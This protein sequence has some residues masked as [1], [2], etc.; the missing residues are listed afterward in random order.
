M[1][2]LREQ[3]TGANDL[4]EWSERKT[5]RWIVH[6]HRQL[7]MSSVSYDSWYELETYETW[8]LQICPKVFHVSIPKRNKSPP[9]VSILRDYA[10]RAFSLQSMCSSSIFS[11]AVFPMYCH[12]THANSLSVMSNAIPFSPDPSSSSLN[13]VLKTSWG[14]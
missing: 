13:M 8:I 3:G 2:V 1:T 12:K 6:W 14:L 4:K 9:S 5:S 11:N 10:L 7:G